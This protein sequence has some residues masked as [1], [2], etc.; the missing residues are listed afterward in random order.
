MRR[1][2][3]LQQFLLYYV[4]DLLIWRIRRNFVI[5]PQMQTKPPLLSSRAR[6]SIGVAIIALVIFLALRY[7]P[8]EGE[9][10]NVSGDLPAT[11]T[12]SVTNLQQ[13]IVVKRDIFY[14]G[15]QLHITDVMLA[16]KFSDDR[17]RSGIYTIRVLVQTRNSTQVPVGIDYASIVR[18]VLPGGETIE[19]KYVS[20]KPVELPN[21]PQSGFI[22]FPA[23]QQIDLSALT[24]RF[25]STTEVPFSGK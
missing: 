10:N 9:A 18:L 11:P 1:G 14:K 20:I 16:S 24:L 2:R 6:T 3:H 15:V 5:M 7:A 22:D 17:K 21:R 8:P 25:D 23:A 19:P 13:T 12:V 4:R